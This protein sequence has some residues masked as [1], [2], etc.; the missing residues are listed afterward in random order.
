M[1]NIS[2]ATVVALGLLELSIYLNNTK[3]RCN[4]QAAI[5]MH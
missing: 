3:G 2:V 5:K 4:K 1:P